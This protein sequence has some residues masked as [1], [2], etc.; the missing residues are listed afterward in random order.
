[1]FF[2]LFALL[3]YK[4]LC[5]T[6]ES[7]KDKLVVNPQFPR[8]MDTKVNSFSV[9][10]MCNAQRP[11]GYERIS[12]YYKHILSLK[13]LSLMRNSYVDDIKSVKKKH[14]QIAGG[15]PA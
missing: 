11:W 10:T 1:M 3:W 12:T 13:T 2:R 6:F 15:R 4:I 9:I 5:V 14:K 8:E 7:K